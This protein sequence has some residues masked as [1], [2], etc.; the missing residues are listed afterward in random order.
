MSAD[1]K[2][3]ANNEPDVDEEEQAEAATGQR[4]EASKAMKNIAED[5]GQDQ[6]AA[7]QAGVPKSNMIL[8]VGPSG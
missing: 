4:A 8:E 6:A 5:E 3:T 1:P 7:S 2:T